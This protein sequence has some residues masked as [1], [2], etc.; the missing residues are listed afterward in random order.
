MMKPT[1]TPIKFTRL[2]VWKTIRGAV[3]VSMAA[4][5]KVVALKILCSIVIDSF[6]MINSL[7]SFNSFKTYRLN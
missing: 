3:T 2:K 4:E 1:T 7:M 6:P 5:R